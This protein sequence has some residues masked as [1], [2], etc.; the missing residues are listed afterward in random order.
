MMPT[1]ELDNINVYASGICSPLH[2]VGVLSFLD[3]YSA[4]NDNLHAVVYIDSANW[5]NNLIPDD[6]V[7]GLSYSAK[8]QS[9]RPSFSVFSL[10]IAFFLLLVRRFSSGSPVYILGHSRVNLK[11]IAALVHA[12]KINTKSKIVTVVFDEG[13][14]SYGGL[15][16]KLAAYR[17]QGHP[18]F[19]M[20]M[21][22]VAIFPLNQ[23]LLRLPILIDKDRRL[24]DIKFGMPKGK[25]EV[26]ASYKRAFSH[27]RSSEADMEIGGVDVLFLTQPMV[28]LG[29]ID[30]DE[31]T[32]LI[33]HVLCLIE[34][35]GLKLWLKPHPAED[36]SFY[37]NL[38]VRTIEL[39]LPAE[40]LAVMYEPRVMLGFTS[41]SL[42]LCNKIF[43][44]KTVSL[45][46]L[47]F[48]SV[49]VERYFNGDRKITTLFNH[50]V[51]FPQSW[52]ALIASI[53][54]E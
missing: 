23:Y 40:A 6:V 4:L 34:E 36:A 54:L 35:A 20:C 26:I 17:R 44:M 10:L 11:L 31:Y 18:G 47:A 50:Y 9:S 14:G 46:K 52:E 27:N 29:L 16:Y 48:P 42:I 43:E 19:F 33:K 39:D 8:F 28:S 2:K 21:L 22:F 45:L 24:F 38:D 5:S 3:E 53:S 12:K 49:G 15:P 13:V 37:R 30:V 51:I 25:K 32:K 1:D 7:N 41:T